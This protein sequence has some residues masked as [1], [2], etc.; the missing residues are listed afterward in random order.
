MSLCHPPVFIMKIPVSYVKY[1]TKIKLGKTQFFFLFYNL[2]CLYIFFS[3]L[4][5]G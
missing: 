3:E 2:F 4:A 1:T 5:G